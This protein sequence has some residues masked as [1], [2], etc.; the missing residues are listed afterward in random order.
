MGE[1]EKIKKIL[2]KN[3]F[4][5]NDFVTNKRVAPFWDVTLYQ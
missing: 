3:K 2:Q 5:Q 1:N 4:T